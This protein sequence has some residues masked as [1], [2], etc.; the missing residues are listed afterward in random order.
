[1]HVSAG[2]RIADSKHLGDIAVESVPSGLLQDGAQRGLQTHPVGSL[3]ADGDIGLE[4]IQRTAP[5]RAAPAQA[6][7]HAAVFGARQ[8]HGHGM[9][10]LGPHIG[11]VAIAE[12]GPGHA[13]DIDGQAFG[14]PQMAA[15]HFRQSQMHHFMHE[16]PIRRQRLGCRFAANPHLDHQAGVIGG[17]AAAH[18]A[19]LHPAEPD[20]DQGCGKLPVY[21][22]R[23]R[24]CAP[25]GSIHVRSTC[26]TLS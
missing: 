8:P 13:F 20:D 14:Q 15:A 21:S 7:I 11:D 2:R 6:L 16:N 3:F 19:A 23:R 4:T 26:L 5:V 1:M 18:T 17:A 25:S 9:A 22:R 24:R 10:V 12:L